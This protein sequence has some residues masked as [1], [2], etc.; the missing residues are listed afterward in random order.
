M[1]SAGNISKNSSPNSRKRGESSGDFFFCPW[2]PIH[3]KWDLLLFLSVVVL[4]VFGLIMVFSSSFIFAQERYGDGFYFIKRQILYAGLGALALIL[5]SSIDYRFWRKWSF[6]VLLGAVVLLVLVL[7]PGIGVKA[8]GAQ[9]WIHL[10]IFNLQPVEL[11]KLAVIFFVSRQLSVKKD[12]LHEFRVGVIAPSFFVIPVLF[13][14]LLQPDFGSTVIL[15][16]ILLGLMFLSGVPYRFLFWIVS[17]GGILASLMILLSPYRM[18]RLFAF[19]D[20]WQDPAGRGFQ[21]LQSFVGLKN[22]GF[23]G[24]GLGNG[25]GKLFF[26]PE[27]HN[28]FIFSVIGEEL[29]LIGV[30]GVILVFSLFIYRGFRVGWKTFRE[31]GDVFSL[32]LASG[33]TLILGG[34]ALINMAV[35]LGLLPTKGL[36]LPF[37]SYGGTALIIDLFAVGI[38]LSISTGPHQKKEK[39]IKEKKSLLAFFKRAPA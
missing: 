28:D 22:G 20:P 31:T 34:Q 29:G 26:L 33:I 21:I 16:G 5:G 3:R 17:A 18:E 14:L 39:F 36:A 32:Y 10:G 19:L 7:I 30:I 15:S 6:V 13:L 2:P 12:R 24:N 23:W 35:V 25:K 11:A 38:L 8:N 1:R 9:R 37:L 27:A 4:V